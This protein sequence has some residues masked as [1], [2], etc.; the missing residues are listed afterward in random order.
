[1]NYLKDLGFSDVDIDDIVK[2]NYSYIIDNL[3][4]NHSNVV[5]IVNYLMGIGIEKGTIKEIFMY[6]VNLF[7][8]TKDE[9]E[10]SFDEYEID[11]VIKSLNYDVNNIELIDFV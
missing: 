7:F 4:L 1:M 10:S 8:K 9:I 6:Q 3:E 2:C 11:S 5:E